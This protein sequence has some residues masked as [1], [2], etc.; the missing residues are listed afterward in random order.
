[1]IRTRPW[2]LWVPT[3]LALQALVA[4]SGPATMTA[5]Q[6]EAFEL[7]RHRERKNDV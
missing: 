1:M 2:A 3:P 7:R 5:R 4:C 6:R